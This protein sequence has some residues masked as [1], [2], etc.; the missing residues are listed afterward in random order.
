MNKVL[1]VVE[2]V[3]FALLNLLLATNILPIMIWLL[4]FGW[5]IFDDKTDIFVVFIGIIIMIFL[6]IYVKNRIFPIIY[7][8]KNKYSKDNVFFER[9]KSDK[10]FRKRVILTAL[11]TDLLCILSIYLVIKSPGILFYLLFGGGVL[12]S[13]LSLQSWFKKRNMLS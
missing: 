5:I 2:Y 3:S 6:S 7:M 12:I 13:Y 4:L 10:L 8:L 9:F 11:I 1:K